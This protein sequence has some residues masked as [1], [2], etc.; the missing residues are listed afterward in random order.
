MDRGFYMY[1]MI[2]SKLQLVDIMVEWFS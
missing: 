1:S 2:C